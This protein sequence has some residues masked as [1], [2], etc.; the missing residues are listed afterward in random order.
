MKVKAGAIF[1]LVGQLVHKLNDLGEEPISSRN[2]KEFL[3]SDF[4]G[5]TKFADIS[6]PLYHEF[7]ATE[8]ALQQFI[9]SLPSAPPTW[10]SS[11]TYSVPSESVLADLA[12]LQTLCQGSFVQLYTPFTHHDKQSRE[13]VSSAVREIIRVSRILAG[14]NEVYW[15]L[16]V[17]VRRILIVVRS[18][19]YLRLCM[20][21]FH[22][23]TRAFSYRMRRT[24]C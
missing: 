11:S 10:L 12:C 20:R 8:D 19:R 2:C 14:T 7:C 13:T 15:H 1:D 6:E 3:T 21:S 18:F 24:R 17:Q 22:G 5:A 9:N 4:P 16:S 23:A